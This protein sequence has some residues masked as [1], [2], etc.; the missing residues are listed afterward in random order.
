MPF[1]AVCFRCVLGSETLAPHEVDT[2]RHRFDVIRVAAATIAAEMVGHQ[3]IRDGATKMLINKA[4][5]HMALTPN[6][7]LP[8]AP[9]V[10]LQSML[11]AAGSR[12]RRMSSRH[13]CRRILY[14]DPEN[15]VV[16][17]IRLS[18]FLIVA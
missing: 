2:R 1:R 8:V 11:P 13:V 14:N 18:F 7:D 12:T 5:Q 6:V 9:R 17:G 16:N 15:D 10:R 4:V 3:P